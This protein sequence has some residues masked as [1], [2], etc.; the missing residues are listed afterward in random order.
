VDR[1]AK[2]DDNSVEIWSHPPKPIPIPHAHLA[3]LLRVRTTYNR[4][5]HREI[6]K[7]MVCR[8]S[9]RDR[10]V[11]FTHYMY[12]GGA[13]HSILDS[14]F[15]LFFFFLLTTETF[16]EAWVCLGNDIFPVNTIFFLFSHKDYQIVFHSYKLSI[17]S[18]YSWKL[19]ITA[20]H[21]GYVNTNSSRQNN[22]T[23]KSPFHTR[24]T[25]RRKLLV[26]LRICGNSIGSELYYRYLTIETCG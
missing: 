4:L 9:R 26:L 25:S 21:R 1:K 14:F 22:H 18:I 16:L 24:P 10:K 8:Q 15:F 13:K 23:S 6:K 12:W 11:R 19:S 20:R 17:L 5:V 2:G 3:N 7:I